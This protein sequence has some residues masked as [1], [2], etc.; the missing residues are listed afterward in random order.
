MW[1][2]ADTGGQL[3]VCHHEGLFYC[4]N[5]CSLSDRRGKRRLEV[6]GNEIF[7]VTP[8]SAPIPVC[9]YWKKAVFLKAGQPGKS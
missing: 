3:M 8:Y 4:Q 7:P 5:V 2:L 6:P 9:T 1:S